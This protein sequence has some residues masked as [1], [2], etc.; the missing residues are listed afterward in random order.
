MKAIGKNIVV[1]KIEQEIKTDSGLLLSAED[2]S[3]F[4][5]Q[6]AQVLLVGTTVL[7]VNEGDVIYYDTRNAYT[8]VIEGETVTIIQE[9]SV[10]VVL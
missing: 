9:G 8:L 1:R 10:V 7:G 6:K 2:V 4:R 5:Y 3:D